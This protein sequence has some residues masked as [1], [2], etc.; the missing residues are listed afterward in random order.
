ME[1]RDQ[2]YEPPALVE[3][4]EFAELT[5]GIPEGPELDFLPSLPLYEPF[6][7]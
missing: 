4:G 5:R 1:S 3:V 7:G 6:L 2:V